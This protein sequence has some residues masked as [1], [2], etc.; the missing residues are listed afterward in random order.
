[1]TYHRIESGSPELA[2]MKPVVDRIRQE[3]RMRKYLTEF[4][5]TF[6]LVFTVG[7]AVLT[8]AAF[9][10]LAIGTV[11]MVLVYLGAQI[12]GG[13]YNPAVTLGVYLRGKMPSADVGPY[14]VAQLAGALV[15]AW[16]AGF[17]VNPPAV[18]TL[19][20]PGRSMA[21]ALVAEF[22]FT[23][24]LVLVF[25]NMATSRSQPG[26]PFFGL[27][28]GF[29]V[30]AGAFAVGA[31]SGGA[32]NPAVAFGATVLGLLSWANIWI[33]LIANLAG[34]AA[35]AIVFRYLNPQ[36]VEGGLLPKLP[37]VPWLSRPSALAS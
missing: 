11:L 37:R 31:V 8:N 20:L 29:T 5:G 25:L 35:A 23:F 17:V 14:W 12:S 4:I 22:V 15:A 2:I 13:H 24:L 27:A 19:S 34:G 7:C 36:D 18:R 33:Y 9:A 10:P 32:F 21:A 3:L 6:A 26:N 16:T 28:I 1:V 30:T